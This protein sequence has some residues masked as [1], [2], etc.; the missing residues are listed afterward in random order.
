MTPMAVQLYLPFSFLKFCFS[1]PFC[2]TLLL[3]KSAVCMDTVFYGRVHF[4]SRAAPLDCGLTNCHARQY[5]SKVTCQCAWFLL[6]TQY[7]VIC[8][9]CFA[10]S[11]CLTLQF[12][13]FEKLI[14]PGFA[15][16]WCH[17]PYKR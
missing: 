2:F 9:V 15:R 8:H 6:L 4:L 13:S 1:N 17:S 3:Q 5:L 10:S 12:S 11:V 16:D 7:P 14:L